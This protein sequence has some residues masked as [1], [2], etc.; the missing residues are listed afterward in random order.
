MCMVDWTLVQFRTGPKPDGKIKAHSRTHHRAVHAPG[1]QRFIPSVID[2]GLVR[3]CTSAVDSWL[4]Y[5][6]LYSLH[7]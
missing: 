2:I 5:I 3:K 4:V 6:I 1:Q 7:A